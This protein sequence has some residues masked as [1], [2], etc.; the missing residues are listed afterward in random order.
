MPEEGQLGVGGGASPPAAN[1]ES[2]G[3]PCPR[4]EPQGPAGL[5]TSCCLEV[6][7]RYSIPFSSVGR[8]VEIWGT[9]T[10]VVIRGEVEEIVRHAR[11][12]RQ[13]LLVNPQHYEGT[14]TDRVSSGRPR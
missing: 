3:A 6:P 1:P 14:S 9:L 7:G 11:G 12:T 8:R 2:G 13:R 10:Y 4:G 5:P